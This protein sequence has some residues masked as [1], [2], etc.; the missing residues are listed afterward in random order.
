[1]NAPINNSLLCKLGFHKLKWI[2]VIYHMKC[3]RCGKEEYV[4]P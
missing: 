3:E 4:G 2:P 1:M